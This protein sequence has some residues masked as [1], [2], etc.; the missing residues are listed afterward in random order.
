MRIYLSMLLAVLVFTTSCATGKKANGTSHS[1]TN[2]K[3]VLTNFT[4]NGKNTKVENTRAFI[5]FDES[6]QSVGG[7]GSCNTFGGSYTLTGNSLTVSKVFSTKMFCQDVQK[8]EDSFL[9]L[10]ENASRYEIKGNT[11]TLYNNQ[12]AILQF[13]ATAA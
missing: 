3:W 6:K 13:I 7:N 5:R 12:G 9:R 1:L 10:L 4:D 8:I 11:L 2:T